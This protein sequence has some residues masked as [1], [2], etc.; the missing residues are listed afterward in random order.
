M[1]HKKANGTWPL[2]T[3]FSKKHEKNHSRNRTDNSIKVNS[4][5]LIFILNRLF[6]KFMCLKF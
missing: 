6:H 3:I 4:T 2:D 1:K 5:L